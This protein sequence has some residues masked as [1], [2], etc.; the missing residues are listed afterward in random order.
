MRAI[1]VIQSIVFGAALL[2]VVL[3][4]PLGIASFVGPIADIA[5]RDWWVG[6]GLTA[7]SIVLRWR[8]LVPGAGR[9]LGVVGVIWVTF[10]LGLVGLYL[11]AFF[12]HGPTLQ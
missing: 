6:V 8:R 1:D 9:V 5:L 3:I 11:V 2:V 12:L 4:G 7:A 10:V